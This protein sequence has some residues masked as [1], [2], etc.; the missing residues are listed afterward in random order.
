MYIRRSGRC[1][2][3]TFFSIFMHIVKK[4]DC[5]IRT[6][7]YKTSNTDNIILAG[8]DNAFLYFPIK[9]YTLNIYLYSRVYVNNI[10]I[11]MIFFSTCDKM[12]V[13]IVWNRALKITFYNHSKCLSI[14]VS[15][16]TFYFFDILLYV[17]NRN[18]RVE[19]S[20]FE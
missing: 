4:I 13:V 7:Q 9:T 5:N 11:K 8:P 15:F 10:S 20:C 1:S 14:F 12:R 16:S 17:R 3:I 6:G 18:E 2:I 19:D